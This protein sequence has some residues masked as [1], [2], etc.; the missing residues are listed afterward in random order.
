L[1]VLGIGRKRYHFIQFN[2]RFFFSLQQ[3]FKVF[4]QLSFIFDSGIARSNV[5]KINKELIK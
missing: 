3:T 2:R 4:K 1:A 5:G